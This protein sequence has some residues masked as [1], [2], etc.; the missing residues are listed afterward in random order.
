MQNNGVPRQTSTTPVIP[1]HPPG[2]G[3]AARLFDLA[4]SWNGAGHLDMSLAHSSNAGQ[5][6]FG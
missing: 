4:L 3:H 6:Q 5:L 2:V 1:K